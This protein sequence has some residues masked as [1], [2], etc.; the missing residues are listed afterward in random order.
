MHPYRGSLWC[1]ISNACTFY[2]GLKHNKYQHRKYSVKK[3][4]VLSTELLRLPRYFW[5]PQSSDS[6]VTS[7]Q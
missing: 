2:H 7:T 1:D 5:D 6:P 4:A 3:Q